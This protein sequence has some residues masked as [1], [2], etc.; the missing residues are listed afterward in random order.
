MFYEV[1]RLEFHMFMLIT[2]HYFLL[3]FQQFQESAFKDICH[4]VYLNQTHTKLHLYAHMT[5]SHLQFPHTFNWSTTDLY[6]FTY[7]FIYVRQ[8][9]IYVHFQ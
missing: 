9:Y 5:S 1:S 8:H 2:S 4:I 7:R 3:K 6:T